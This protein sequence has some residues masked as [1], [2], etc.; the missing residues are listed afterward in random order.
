MDLSHSEEIEDSQAQSLEKKIYDLRN[1]ME[2]GMSLSSNL[3]FQNLVE[4]ILF[5][6]IGQLF[7][8]RTQLTP[9][10]ILTGY[11]VA[12]VLLQA[13]GVYQYLVD[14]GGAGATVPLT[15]F[16]YSLAKGVAKAVA[17]KGPLGIL[18]GGLTATSGGIAAAVVFAVLAAI[19][20]KPK[21][22]R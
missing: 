22:K 17:E 11:V 8:D 15:G 14:W 18:T 20:F 10:R 1:L 4:S 5:S 19:F 3:D 21:E 16:G 12:G 7:I 2:V 6:C 13:V 9:A